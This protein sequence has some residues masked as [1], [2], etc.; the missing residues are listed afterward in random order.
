MIIPNSQKGLFIT[1]EG[2]EGVGKSTC[3]KFI[4]SY[5]KRKQIPHIT[6]REPGGTPFAEA[7][8][9]LL[10]SSYQ[11]IVCNDA[12]LLLF[13][14]G[15]A[16]HIA[17]IILP[18]LNEGK[19]VICD[20]FTDASYAYQC[21]G[22]GIPKERIAFLEQWVQGD[23]RPDMTLLF[24]AP[25][26]TALSRITKRGKPDRIETEKKHFFTRVRNCY[27]ELA[28]EQ[29]ARFRIINAS[30]PLTVVKQELRN[31][32]DHAITQ[33]MKSENTL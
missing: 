17:N 25:V 19:W 1:L 31:I 10:L 22:R 33:Q 27:L 18:A 21:G 2:I 3:L 5:L 14:A 32:I 20:R 6:T 15:R 23:L 30:R 29:P 26:Q 24:D 12:E 4:Q 16:Q 13:F 8:R 9:K 7:I 28:K 11:E